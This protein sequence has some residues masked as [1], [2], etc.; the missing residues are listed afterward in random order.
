MKDAKL[1]KKY[2]PLTASTYYIMIS[3]VEPLHGYCIM[4]YTKKCSNGAVK[5]GPSTLY[6][7][8]SKLQGE[9]LITLR[10]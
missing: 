9:K 10:G 2:L 4:Q 5:L 3:L 7:A 6:D 8:L 1:V